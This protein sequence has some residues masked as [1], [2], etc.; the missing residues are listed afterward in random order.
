M[1]NLTP[2]QVQAELDR[3]GGDAKQA[4]ENLGRPHKTVLHCIWRHKLSFKSKKSPID[5]SKLQEMYNRL[6]SLS[7]VASE[8]GVTREGVRLVMKRHG[9]KVSKLVRYSVN[10]AFFSTDTERSFY[11]AGFLA[12]DGC[13]RDRHSRKSKRKNIYVALSIRDKGHLEKLR[14]DLSYTGGVRSYLVKN[15]KRNSEWNDTEKCELSI[16][17][18][19]MFDNLARFNIVPRKSLVYTFPKWLVS[20]DLVRHY[21]RGYFDG[22]GSLYWMKHKTKADQ[23]CFNLRGTP[24][25]LRT[26]RSILERECGLPKRK[27]PI[28]INN[29]IGVL[30]YGGNLVVDKIGQWL[31]NPSEVFLPRKKAFIT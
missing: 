10:D 16:E 11:W 20:H 3:C 9:M 7:A 1:A 29:G 17:S 25:F 18:A 5:P 12:A 2:E 30:E 8:L 26:Y 6:G 28:R 15:S 21:M 31:Y 4:S 23:L 24:R 22:D 19:R 14:M 13:L 27:G